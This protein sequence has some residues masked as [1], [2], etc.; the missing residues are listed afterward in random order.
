MNKF[1]SGQK[2]VT[3]ITKA[4]KKVKRYRIGGDVIHEFIVPTCSYRMGVEESGFGAAVISNVLCMKYV[5]DVKYFHG[6]LFLLQMGMGP[7]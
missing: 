5:F 2:T 1:L 7:T 4:D 6:L 3:H